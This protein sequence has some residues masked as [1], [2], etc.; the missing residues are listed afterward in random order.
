MN[1]FITNWTSQLSKDGTGPL[2]FPSIIRGY[3]RRAVFSFSADL[4]DHTFSMSARQLPDAVGTAE[5]VFT[6]TTGA[7][8][9]GVTNVT[10]EVGEDELDNLPED[11]LSDG[12]VVLIYDMIA[13][14][15]SAA[16]YRIIGGTLPIS[17]RVT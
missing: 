1:K 12:V 13:T 11:L 14:P 6:C 15:P 7:Y 10:V 2:E 17:G 5:L 16:P 3:G 9:N 4:S 8:S